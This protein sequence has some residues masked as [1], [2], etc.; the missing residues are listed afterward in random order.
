MSRLRGNWRWMS[1]ILGALLVA[2]F[3]ILA[4]SGRSSRKAYQYRH[5]GHRPDLGARFLAAFPYW[6][7]VKFRP[8][9][10]AQVTERLTQHVIHHGCSGDRAVGVLGHIASAQS[11]FFAWTGRFASSLAEL[12][13][14]QP[15][16]AVYLGSPIPSGFQIDY[17]SNHDTWSAQ[18]SKQAD[19]PGH[20]LVVASG[21]YFS[22]SRRAT[23][24]DW[25]LAFFK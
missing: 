12:T 3:T 2:M 20:Y 18:I 13:A 25:P 8:W 23:T 9:R 5:C 15:G 11:Q 21:V 19:L 17:E 6:Q 16:T 7:N 22:E 24:N 1:V 14:P 4:L 10:Q